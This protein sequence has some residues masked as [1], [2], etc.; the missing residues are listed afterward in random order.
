MG[1]R[2]NHLAI[3]R[4]VQPQTLEKKVRVGARIVI[5]AFAVVE[6]GAVDDTGFANLL[7]VLQVAASNPRFPQVAQ[8]PFD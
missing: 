1:C 4:C 5:A 2:A 6:L 8:F 7:T 3:R